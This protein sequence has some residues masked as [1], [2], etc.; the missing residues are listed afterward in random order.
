MND[1]Q[2]QRVYRWEDSFRSFVERTA[3][4]AD[5]RKLIKKACSLYGVDAPAVQ[6]RSRASGKRM[7]LSSDYD[8]SQHSITIGFTDCNHAIA[9]H[10]TAHAIIDEKYEQVEDHGPEFLG[11]YLDLL[12]WANVA[13]RSALHASA[14]AKRLRWTPARR[15]SKKAS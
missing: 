7:R 14:R 15:A 6:F 8:P 3:T 12:E 2:Q 1:P 11:V 4:R 9:L 10:E 5:L 13:P